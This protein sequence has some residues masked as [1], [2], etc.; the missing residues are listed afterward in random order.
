MKKIGLFIALALLSVSVAVSAP[1]KGVPA[2]QD[3]SVLIMDDIRFE[4]IAYTIDSATNTASVTLT[5]TCLSERSRELKVNV[6]GT[7]LVDD[8][9]NAYYFSA[10]TMGRVL[11]R[12]EDRQ[13]YLHY[14][15]QPSAPVELTI[16]AQGISPQAKAI[17]MVKV[18]FEDRKDEGRFLEAY[19]LAPAAE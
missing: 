10:L 7:Q 17:H 1:L 16:T 2:E 13:N 8:Q 4:A 14:L 19:L 12:F 5:L 11:M 6:C 9:R 3:S 15:L 18:V